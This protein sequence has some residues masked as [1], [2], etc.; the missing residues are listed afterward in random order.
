MNNIGL[1]WKKWFYVHVD[2]LTKDKK[3]V[4][5]IVPLRSYYHRHTRGIFWEMKYIIP[6]ADQAWFRYLL[7]WACPPNI[8]LMKSTQTESMKKMW[9]EQ[10]CVQD[11]LVPIKTL[12]ETLLFMNDRLKLYP[13]WL[14]PHLV[15]KHPQGGML[16][17]LW[18][19][20]ADEFL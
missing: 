3:T 18:R 19:P 15:V 10:F 17:D 13:I 11:M 16:L 7:G 2:E 9:R 8:P 20:D 12:S 14:C 6:F 4:V 1:W 5:E